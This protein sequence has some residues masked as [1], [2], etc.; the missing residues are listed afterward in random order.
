MQREEPLIKPEYFAK[1]YRRVEPLVLLL[2]DENIY[3]S[4][5]RSGDLK[6]ERRIL[7]ARYSRVKGSGSGVA[8]VGIGAPVAAISAEMLIALG[9]KRLVFFGS[10]GAMDPKLSIG[11]AGICSRAIPDDG[12]SRSYATDRSV[13][14]ASG[15]L[16]DDL[17]EGLGIE[18]ELTALTTDAFF[19]ETRGKLNRFA[20]LGAQVVEMEAAAIFAVAEYRGVEAA[21]VLVVSDRFT[22]RGWTAGFLHPRFRLSARSVR[23]KLLEWMKAT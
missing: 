17:K 15:R 10:A 23:K 6:R 19:M 18:R 13:L 2:F 22:E 12:T 8:L 3:K 16:V 4:L 1:F 14:C 21:G 7:Q 11:D 5:L 20:G 9:A